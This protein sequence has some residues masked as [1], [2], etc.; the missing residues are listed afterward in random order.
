MTPKEY[1][2]IT[3]KKIKETPYSSVELIEEAERVLEK[4]NINEDS[5]KQ[6]WI[7]LYSELTDLF[8]IHLSFGMES[9]GSGELSKIVAMAKAIITKKAS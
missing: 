6:F 5:K 3:A 1:A 4:S 7:E 2:A 8:G 9:Q